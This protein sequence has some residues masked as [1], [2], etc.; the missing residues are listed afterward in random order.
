[1]RASYPV[2]VVE[3]SRREGIYWESYYRVSIS[4]PSHVVDI[5]NYEY[6][7]SAPS[8][9]DSADDARNVRGSSRFARVISAACH[10]CRS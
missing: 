7:F 9:N 5:Y 2:Y 4:E 1:M 6:F 10:G 3:V 8:K